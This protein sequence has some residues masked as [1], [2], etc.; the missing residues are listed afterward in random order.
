M[1]PAPAWCE[2]YTRLE[3]QDKGRGPVG[4]D[5]WGFVRLVQSRQFGIDDLPDLSEEYP[6]AENHSAVALAVRKYEAALIAKWF[7]VEHP[8]S[9]DI[10]IIRIATRPWHCGVC[11]GDDWML[12]ILKGVNVGLEHFRREPWRNRIEGFYRHV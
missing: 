1:M 11:V 6:S 5:C 9:G 3:Y 7:P 8:L 12:H 4:F 10:V 2:S